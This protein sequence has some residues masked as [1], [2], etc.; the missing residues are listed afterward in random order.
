M[1]QKT[2]AGHTAG[3][4]EEALALAGKGRLGDAA[5]ARLWALAADG[6]I[7]L[8]TAQALVEMDVAARGA[9]AKASKAP[10]AQQAAHREEIRLAWAQAVPSAL[11]GRMELPLATWAVLGMTIARAQFTHGEWRAELSLTE[12]QRR[13]GGAGRKTV[14]AAVARLEKAGLVR[15]IRRRRNRRFSEVNVYVLEHPEAVR[16][17]PE[18]PWREEEL[19]QASG[20]PRGTVVRPPA[21]PGAPETAPEGSRGPE[22]GEGREAPPEGSQAAGR[23][24]SRAPPVSPRRGRSMAPSEGPRAA[25]GDADRRAAGSS[26]DFK[27]SPRETHNYQK[28]DSTT[29]LQ[30]NRPVRAKPSVPPSP[31]RPRPQNKK[32]CSRQQ[33]YKR[34]GPPPERPAAVRKPPPAPLPEDA[35]RFLARSLAVELGDR[36]GGDHWKIAAGLLEE[37]LPEFDRTAWE[38]ARSRHGARAPLAVIETA[39]MVRIRAGTEDP[40]RSGPAYL[41]GIL[42]REPADCRP[43]ITLQRLAAAREAAVSGATAAGRAAYPSTGGGA[44]EAPEDVAWP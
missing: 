24:P 6:S 26:P 23:E 33:G 14:V 5:R 31:L 18:T 4:L 22:A 21:S 2:R 3:I 19:P 37:E 27:G 36:Q 1:D 32:S 44:P 38:K 7:G 12:M 28:K 20:I 29:E 42:R 17:A 8:E 39:L 9:K 41:G 43:E 15:A 25:P 30:R 35:A 34:R 40:I 10:A 13:L 16:A 11:R